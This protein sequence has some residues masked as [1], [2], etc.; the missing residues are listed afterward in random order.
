VQ[1]ASAST[2]RP[3]NPNPLSS[4]FRARSAPKLGRRN[5]NGG[6]VSF[7]SALGGGR[8]SVLARN[9]LL[10][11][12]RKREKENTIGHDF[13]I[14]PED[15]KHASW[16]VLM[17]ILIMI[18]VVTLPLSLGWECVNE[19]LFV[20][21][22]L[23]DGLFLCD[24]VKNFNTGYIDENESVVMIRRSVFWN[25]FMG[26][27]WID[28]LS[29][30]PIDP[31]LDAAGAGGSQSQMCMDTLDSMLLNTEEDT[32]F[33][34]SEL[35]KATKGLKMLKLLRMAKLFRLLRLSRVFR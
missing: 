30:F 13:L 10:A 16:D 31:V 9:V 3:L 20:L 23:V 35:T 28:L 25:Y 8:M 29:S 1:R 11:H 2:F 34:K 18:T 7:G 26:Y 6:N 32:G 19:E 17:S 12:D 14:H 27:F 21:N 24:V 15:W 5:T 33:D 22:S 4:S